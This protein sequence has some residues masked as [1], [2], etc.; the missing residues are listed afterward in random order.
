MIFFLFSTP[1]AIL[2]LFIFVLH[3]PLNH[4]DISPVL[5]HSQN[6]DI[7][8]YFKYTHSLGYISIFV[9]NSVLWV[10]TCVFWVV[11]TQAVC[12]YLSRSLLTYL[13]IMHFCMF[14]LYPSKYVKKTILKFEIWQNG[15]HFLDN[16]FKVIFLNENVWILIKISLKGPINNIPALVEIM[17][18][19]PT[20]QQVI[21]GTND[22]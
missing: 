21:I 10:Q 11:P 8:N 14:T 17:A 15:C 22:G 6:T 20:R 18:L 4:S 1:F 13:Y 16:I 2:Y 5:F 12:T 19:A 9:F 7:T 3:F